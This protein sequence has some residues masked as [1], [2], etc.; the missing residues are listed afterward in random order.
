MGGFLRVLAK[1]CVMDIH[2][3]AAGP[4]TLSVV[5]SILRTCVTTCAKAIAFP[6][7]SFLPL[8]CSISKSYLRGILGGHRAVFM[9]ILGHDCKNSIQIR[10]RPSDK[11]F[12]CCLLQGVWCQVRHKPLAHGP[13]RAFK[14]ARS[15]KYKWPTTSL[16]V[17]DLNWVSR[18]R[19]WSGRLGE[20]SAKSD[21]SAVWS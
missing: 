21:A 9:G 17:H 11:Y 10:R 16:I 5:S 14:A 12:E 1:H 15:N 2:F 13:S 8:S 20:R 19:I 7:P 3:W 18:L 4:L 6:P